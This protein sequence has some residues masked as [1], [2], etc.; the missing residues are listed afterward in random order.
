M[1]AQKAGYFINVISSYVHGYHRLSV[2]QYILTLI[3][4][5]INLLTY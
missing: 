2:N 1:Q 3:N 5:L 4:S